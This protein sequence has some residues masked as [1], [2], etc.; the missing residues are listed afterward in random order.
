MS[1]ID[2]IRAERVAAIPAQYK[3]DIL[4]SVKKQLVSGRNGDYALIDGAA[5]YCKQEWKFPEREWE[6]IVTAPFRYHA[7]ISDWLRSLGFSCC[8]HYN[9]GGVDNGMEVRLR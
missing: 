5:H 7:A 4:K 3:D 8:R 2:D 9:K 1:I 6:T